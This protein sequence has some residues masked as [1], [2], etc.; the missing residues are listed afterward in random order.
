[1]SD[2]QEQEKNLPATQKRLDQ[3]RE[4]G[5]VARSV[6][7]ATALMLAGGV[8]AIT[9]G[10]PAWL[11]SSR[12][13]LG[14]GLR[15]RRAEVFNEGAMTERLA[16]FAWE[17]TL[18]A[19][20]LVG[21]VTLAA[22][23]GMLAVGG[24]NFTM[25]AVAPKASR[26]SPMNMVQRLFSLGG[27]GEVAKTIAKAI[28][29][30]AVAGWFV[31]NHREMAA[32]LG[33]MAL[34]Q[35]LAGAGSMATGI[36]GVMTLVAVGVAVVDVP[37]S[38][39]RYH[40][41]LKMTLEEIKRESRESDGDPHLKGRIRQLQRDTARRRMMSEVPKADVVVT[42]PTHYAVALSYKD[43]SG[44]APRV[45]AKGADAVAA[46]IRQIANESGVPLLEAPPLARA[47]HHNVDVGDEIPAPLFG[48]VAQVL[49]WVYELR[50]V[51]GAGGAMPR[52]PADLAVPAGMDPAEQAATDTANNAAATGA[53]TENR[54]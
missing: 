40:A 17:G 15:L 6:E 23:G 2:E 1:M 52:T 31:W 49:A 8:G 28:A 4:D 43:G 34:P 51:R 37:L 12:Q 50:R 39:Y 16:N 19:L 47:L 38:L 35:A 24:W 44:A 5:Q 26:M 53:P 45:V 7:L 41:G 3:A 20:P 48:A 27:M 33:H 13:F 42:N 18:L 9:M 30:A 32:Q 36:L 10:G 25:G 29:F 21:I 22:V 14:A 46:R 54:A 11:E